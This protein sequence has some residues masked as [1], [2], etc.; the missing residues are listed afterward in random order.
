MFF[1]FNQPSR[2]PKEANFTKTENGWKDASLY[3]NLGMYFNYFPKI[4]RLGF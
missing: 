4:T 1:I 3:Y 2:K